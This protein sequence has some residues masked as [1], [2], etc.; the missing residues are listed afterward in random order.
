LALASAIL[1]V[2]KKIGVMRIPFYAFRRNL[3]ARCFDKGITLNIADSWHT[4]KWCS[5]CGAVGKS[6]DAANYSLFGCKCGLVVNSDRKA[7][8][9]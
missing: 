3:E 1:I 9:L 6:H 2:K 5:R 7:H 4:S 8:K